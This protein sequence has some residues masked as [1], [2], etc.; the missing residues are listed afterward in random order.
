MP[1]PTVVLQQLASSTAL[2]VPNNSTAT[3]AF[4]Q[5]TV[6][7]GDIIAV[8]GRTE[9]GSWHYESVALTAGTA[10][11]GTAFSR[12]QTTGPAGSKCG[13]DLIVGTIATAGT[14][15]FT[16][17][18]R[19]TTGTAS[20]RQGATLVVASGAAGFNTFLSATARQLS[21]TPASTN[22]CIAT[23]TTDWSA[24]ASN[25]AS[26]VPAGQGQ[27]IDIRATDGVDQQASAGANSSVFNA[28][29]TDTAGAGATTY[30]L[31]SPSA[32]AYNLTAV[33]FTAGAGGS[34]LPP[35]IVLAPRRP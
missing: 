28:H 24:A 9:D 15:T 26:F 23:F 32:G 6:A 7:A 20:P 12:L 19:S 11:M 8:Q 13:N 18:I 4:T 2:S 35:I 25:G 3:R 22:S 17:T 14:A 27:V 33:E 30:G 16:C 34:T 31:N 21:I 10:T 1:A 5:V 29:W